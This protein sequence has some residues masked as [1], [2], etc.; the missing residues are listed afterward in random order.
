MLRS[1]T[2]GVLAVTSWLL[3]AD[4][5]TCSGV[6]DKNITGIINEHRERAVVTSQ[7]NTMSGSQIS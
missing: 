4:T 1:L 7:K 2:A 6:T 5:Q 3:V